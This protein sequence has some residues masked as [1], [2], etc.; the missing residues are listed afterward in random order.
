[1]ASV[2]ITN[3]PEDLHRRLV[4]EAKRSGRSIDQQAVE[5]LDRALRP[6]PPVT[7]PTP[8]VPLRPIGEEEIAAAIREGRE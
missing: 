2:M 8:I 4:Q 1:M 7:L 3:M 6:V 5:L